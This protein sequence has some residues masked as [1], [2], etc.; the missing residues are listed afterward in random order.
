M[1]KAMRIFDVDFAEIAATLYRTCLPPPVP[2][3]LNVTSVAY[4]A[5][6]QQQLVFED[7]VGG[8]LFHES[9]DLSQL[10]IEARTFQPLQ[11][12]VNRPYTV[13]RTQALNAN[14]T[15]QS[16]EY[17]FVWYT[18][19]AAPSQA[20]IDGTSGIKQ[21]FIQALR[22]SGMNTSP[23]IKLSSEYSEQQPDLGQ[24][25]WASSSAFLPSLD[26]ALSLP[27]G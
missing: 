2:P 21:L 26:T 27:N 23:R 17:L 16:E 10:T 1:V 25:V 15:V 9:I 7:E 4:G 18:N 22:A 6:C 14:P 11:V 12:I 20:V 5:L 3:E 8:A 19:V 13:P 24:L